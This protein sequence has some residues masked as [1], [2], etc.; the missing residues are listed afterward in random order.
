[1]IIASKSVIQQ[2]RCLSQEVV[3]AHSPEPGQRGTVVFRWVDCNGFCMRSQC[4]HQEV[5][6][7]WEMYGEENMRWYDNINNEWDVCTE[8]F[9]EDNFDLFESMA[10]PPFDFTT[11]APFQSMQLTS[12]VL[13]LYPPLS[14]QPPLHELVSDCSADYVFDSFFDTLYY[15]YG[16]LCSPKII[17]PPNPAWD[18]KS[19]CWYILDNHSPLLAIGKVQ[20]TSVVAFFNLSDLSLNPVSDHAADFPIAPVLLDGER[21]FLLSINEQSRDWCIALHDPISVLQIFQQRWHADP[22]SLIRWL[23]CHG[24]LLNTFLIMQIPDENPLPLKLGPSSP[25]PRVSIQLDW[26]TT[27]YDMYEQAWNTFLACPYVCTALL[28]GGIIG[29]LA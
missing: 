24:V 15:Q 21:Y 25:L 29:H 12:P 4:H 13:P 10:L 23:L 11:F 22:S 6:T 1:M 20:C 7:I 19:V 14:P 3:M 17:M 27:D 8:F 16:I 26:W 18:F 9:P 28:K 2:Q 5:T